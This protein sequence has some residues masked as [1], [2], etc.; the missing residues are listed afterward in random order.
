MIKV[1]FLTNIPSPY[2]I[3]FF[4]KLGE[5]CDLTVLFERRYSSERDDSWKNV[6]LNNFK[7]IFMSGIRIGVDKAICFEVIK[8]LKR[9]RYDHIIVSNPL[10]L[11][12]AWS[13]EYMRRHGIPFWIEGDGGLP[14]E[15]GFIKGA[16]KR[17]LLMGAI[18]Y[19]STSELHDQYYEV[20]GIDK[21]RI[22][23]YPFTSVFA[24]EIAPHVAYYQ[25]KAELRNKLGIKEKKTIISVGQ[26][27]HRK[28]FDTLLKAMATLPRSIGLYIVGGK[29][30]NDIQL[31]IDEYRLY[32]VHIIDFKRKPELRDFYRMADLFVLATREDIWGLVVNEAMAMGLPI[33]TT[34]KCV[35]GTEL[36][37]EG[38]NGF[39]FE[40]EDVNALSESIRR[41]LDNCELK[42]SMGKESLNIIRNYT[43][44]EMALSHVRIL[45]G[46]SL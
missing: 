2:R 10:T 43:I 5:L 46:D 35:S 11:T 30:S 42:K 36:V 38:E 32:N 20:H 7:G 3:D 14:A 26:I 33:I 41:V 23:R 16:I 28:G 19:F 1:L 22:H 34:T 15:M 6:E 21:N 9:G 45:T 29:A 13:T 24:Q 18:G 12:G 44:E 37:K 4:S 27:I 40:P 31:L 25:E 8:Y 39:L 17:R